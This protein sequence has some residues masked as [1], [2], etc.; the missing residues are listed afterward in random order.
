LIQFQI[1]SQAMNWQMLALFFSLGIACD[2]HDNERLGIGNAGNIVQNN[3][4]R[5][6]LDLVLSPHRK[7]AI[8]NVRVFNGHKLLD[9]STVVIDGSVIGFDATGAEIIEGAGGVLLPGLIDSHCHP[10]NM[11]HME[12][13]SRYGVTTGVVAACSSRELCVSL[14]NHPGLADLRLASTPAMSPLGAVGS[15]LAASGASGQNLVYNASQAIPWVNNQVDQGSDFIKLISESIGFDQQTL[16]AL[17]DAA[18]EQKKTVIC[19]ASEY[20]AVEQAIAAKVDQLHHAPLDKVLD[21]SL[22]KL[23][24]VNKQ[25]SVPTLSMMKAIAKNRPTSN[26]SAALESVRLLH[27][28]GVPILAGTDSNMQPF[29]PANVPFGSSMHFEMELLVDA[30]LSTI[31]ALQAATSRPAKYFGLKDRGVIAPGMRADLILIDGDPIADIKA[32]RRIK[33]VWLAGIEFAGT[34]GVLAL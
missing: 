2:F 13:L 9:P 12:D 8:K 25:I 14:L 3:L 20:G 15:K 28:I 4:A 11:S 22:A 5:T 10:T 19:H 1:L 16:N 29:V 6:S 31:E 30:G 33:R 7:I 21:D 27:S 23:I 32:T 18:H 34:V 26:Y 24:Y 17:T